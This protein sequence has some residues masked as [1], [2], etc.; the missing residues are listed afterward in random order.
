MVAIF[1][2]FAELDYRPKVIEMFVFRCEKIR[3][4]LPK[5]SAIFMRCLN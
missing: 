5:N 2:P 1:L 3:I 4:Y